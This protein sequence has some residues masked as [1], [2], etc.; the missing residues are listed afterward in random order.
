VV[1]ASS[2]VT[3]RARMLGESAA[4][5][6]KLSF[7]VENA[8]PSAIIVPKFQSRRYTLNIFDDSGNLVDSEQTRLVYMP[9]LS[10]EDFVQVPVG[11]SHHEELRLKVSV[12]A[13]QF[14]L[15]H[16]GV[17]WRLNEPKGSV[18]ITFLQV[19]PSTVLET[20]DT[21][22]RIMHFFPKAELLEAEIKSSRLP[23]QLR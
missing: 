12:S 10:P 18:Q 13:N 4:G 11:E 7:H 14:Q 5:E 23:L 9:A 8:S 1:T 19:R 20:R 21:V 3:L 17:I 2:Q 22:A 16:E 15:D 6:V